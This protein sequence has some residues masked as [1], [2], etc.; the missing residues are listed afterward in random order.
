MKDNI[1]IEINYMLRCHLLPIDKTPIRTSWEP[2]LFYVQ[3]V[4]PIE[5]FA[6]KIVALVNR[7]AARDLYDIYRLIRSGIIDNPQKTC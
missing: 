3:G 1:K 2:K 5:I 6:S 4:N 7:T